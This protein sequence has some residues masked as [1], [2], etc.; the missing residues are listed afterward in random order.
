M[1][2]IVFDMS[3]I[4]SRLGVANPAGAGRE[5]GR[6]FL[7]LSSQWLERITCR[8][9]FSRM[10]TATSGGECACGGVDMTVRTVL[11][12]MLAVCVAFLLPSASVC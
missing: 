11:S 12:S 8:K 9:P 3:L 1:Q 2:A 4:G 7:V 10:P 5:G 6:L